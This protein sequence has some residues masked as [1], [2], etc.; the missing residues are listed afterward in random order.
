[1]PFTSLEGF[2][3]IQKH[4]C[5]KEQSQIELEIAQLQVDFQCIKE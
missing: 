1:M 5:F 4:P 3:F 2:V